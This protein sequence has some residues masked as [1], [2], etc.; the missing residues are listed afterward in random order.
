MICLSY[1]ATK[2]WVIFSVVFVEKKNC[3]TRCYLNLKLWVRKALPALWFHGHWKATL[4][5][6]HLNVQLSARLVLAQTRVRQI[7][8]DA[9]PSSLFGEARERAGNY[10]PTLWLSYFHLEC[11]WCAVVSSARYVG[12]QLDRKQR[13]ERF[14]FSLGWSKQKSNKNLRA[15]SDNEDKAEGKSCDAIDYLNGQDDAIR[16]VPLI[17]PY[18]ASLVNLPGYGHSFLC[19]Y[20]TRRSRSP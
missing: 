12:S 2:A 10:L 3:P 13:I 5:V 14:G 4:T 15:I 11:A 6:D 8:V 18:L 19:V 1:S 20:A 9:I 16:G 7:V 17:I